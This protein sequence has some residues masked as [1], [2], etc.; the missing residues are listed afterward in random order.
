[1]TNFD[2]IAA[3]MPINAQA[4]ASAS[5]G[6][7][8][9]FVTSRLTF[10]RCPPLLTDAEI[11][12]RA[13]SGSSFVDFTGKNIGRLTVL[14]MMVKPEGRRNWEPRWVCRC[15]CGT[16]TAIKSKHMGDTDRCDACVQTAIMRGEKIGDKRLQ[17][18]D[19]ELKWVRA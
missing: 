6:T 8:Y 17:M 3:S 16:F 12:H 7:D 1:M 5:K 11:A 13:S 15:T 4:G 14:G 2:R 18:S 9:Q 19:R 10:D